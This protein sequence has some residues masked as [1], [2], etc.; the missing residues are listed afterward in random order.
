MTNEAIVDGRTLLLACLAR[1]QEI[2]PGLDTDAARAQR[3]A[4]AELD[5]W[6][7]PNFARLGATL[8]RHFPGAGEY[9]FR[10]LSPST[11][12]AAGKVVATLLQRTRKARAG[13]ARP[14]AR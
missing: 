2:G 14:G 1:P 12:S 11:G 3:A 5:E 6:D 13:S 10:D 9:V 8:E 4:V 7:E